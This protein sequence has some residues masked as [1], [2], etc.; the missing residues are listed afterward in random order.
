MEYYSKPLSKERQSYLNNLNTI[1]AEYVELY[2]DFIISLTYILTDSYFGDN[3]LITDED[4]KGHFEWSWKK[5]IKNFEKEH[6][7]FNVS[8]EHYYYF[9]RYFSD[10]FYNVPYKSSVVKDKILWFWDNIMNH[11]RTK[12]S[13]EYDVFVDIYKIQTESFNKD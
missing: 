3:F 8:G 5:N 13:T 4:R 1:Q 9:Q 12:S 10:F 2:K 7:Y 11:E 6:I